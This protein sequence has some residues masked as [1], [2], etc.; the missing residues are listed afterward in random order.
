MGS[1]S[2]KILMMLNDENNL[3]IKE[4][5]TNSNRSCRERDV[6]SN[7]AANSIENSSMCKYIVAIS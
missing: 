7:R 3:Q 1:R 5:D 6:A 2:K 4:T